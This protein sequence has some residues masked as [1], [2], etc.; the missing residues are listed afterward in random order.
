MIGWLGVVPLAAHGIAL[1]VAAI[2]FMVPLGI[3]QASSVRVGQAAGRRDLTGIGYAGNAA[4]IIAVLFAFLSILVMVTI[5][6]TLISM[7]LDADGENAGAVVTYAVPLLGMAALFQLVDSVQAVSSGNLRGLQD[8]RIPLLL[9]TISYWGVGMTV[10]YVLAFPLGLGGVGVWGGLA[11]GLA[12][13]A[14]LLT[15]R[16]AAREK[17]NLVPAQPVPAAE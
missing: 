13:A 3:S 7:F 2:A 6:S 11:S 1:Q 14:I 17:L 12:S 16:F 5:P 15:L 8:T 9:A 4:L 10:A